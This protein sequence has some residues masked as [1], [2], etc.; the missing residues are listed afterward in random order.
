VIGGEARCHRWELGTDG[1]AARLDYLPALARASVWM[2][3]NLRGALL[4]STSNRSE[5]VVY[6]GDDIVRL[7]DV[8]DVWSC[9]VPRICPRSV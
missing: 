1:F 9:P 2:L 8:T 4:L 7:D 3:A 6:R 5:A